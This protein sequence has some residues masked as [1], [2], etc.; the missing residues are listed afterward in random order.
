[1]S[2]NG[3]G[4]PGANGARTGTPGNGNELAKTTAGPPGPAD[5]LPQP[6][7]LKA[8][9]AAIAG[10]IS[11]ESLKDVMDAQ[12]KKAKGGD[13]RAA[14]FVFDQA[15]KLVES[16]SQRPVEITQN[17]YYVDGASADAESVRP[18]VPI[19]GAKVHQAGR[20]PFK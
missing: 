17:N 2:H 8:M 5:L 13:L 12:M 14:K 4:T 20:N 6:D 1:M 10:A 19:N 3:T 11:G 18:H 9:R 16:E 7:W 15:H